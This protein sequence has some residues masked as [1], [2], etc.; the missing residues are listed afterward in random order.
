MAN[1]GADLATSAAKQFVVGRLRGTYSEGVLDAQRVAELV[2]GP[3]GGRVHSIPFPDHIPLPAIGITRYGAG[4]T[5]TPLGAGQPSVAATIRLQ[6]K[7]V[8]EGYDESPIE[9]AAAILNQLLDGHTALVDLTKPQ[10]GGTYGTFHVECSRESELLTD[11][12]PEEDGTVYQHLGGI[13]TFF[14]TR[15]G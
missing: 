3:T 14:V 8:C 10:G 6:I 13:Y 15:V 11:L 12:P 2:A 4:S 5:A 9:A 1:L 7:A